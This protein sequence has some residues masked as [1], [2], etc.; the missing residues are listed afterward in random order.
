MAITFFGVASSPADNGTSATSPVTVTP[1][2]SM[3]AGDLVFLYAYCRTNSVQVL[4]SNSGGQSFT[5]INSAHQVGWNAAN[6]VLTANAF[7]CRFNG[8][9]SANPSCSFGATTNTNVVML[10]FRPTVGTNVWTIDS[11]KDGSFTQQTAA[12]SFTVT[13]WTPAN[14][15]NVNIAV[16]NTA[17]D[18]T[19]G[20]LTGT[21]W[22]K[23]SLGAQYRNTSGQD[24]SSSFA[25]Q[26]QG[27][28]AGT[29]NVSQTQLTNGNDG[30]L[31]YGV[32]FYEAAPP[33]TSL[34]D[35]IGMGII[36]WSR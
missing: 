30:G 22:V 16:W 12:A 35:M 23:T 4:M 1:P 9:W 19:W 36:P 3:V 28:A 21:N 2:V 29:N 7:W 34:K 20:T 31:T 5:Y 8:T 13:G 27:A 15:N 32:C 17:D 26:I 14:S 25:Y 24:T 33:A 6:A 11:G 18:N 10:V